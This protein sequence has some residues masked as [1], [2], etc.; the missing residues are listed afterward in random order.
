VHGLLDRVVPVQESQ[1]VAAALREAGVPVKLILVKGAG[2][3]LNALGGKIDPSVD[4][5]R[6]QVVA[7]FS[8]HIRPRQ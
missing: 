4:E 1:S 2:H 6:A 5:V 3:G 8:E 7:F